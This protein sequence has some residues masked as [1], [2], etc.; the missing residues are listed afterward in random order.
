MEDKE[1]KGVEI[2][3]NGEEEEKAVDESLMFDQSNL[4]GWKTP[5]A[6]REKN[7]FFDRQKNFPLKTKE[8]RSLLDFSS[9]SSIDSS[10]DS[11][12]SSQIQSPIKT[13]GDQVEE[14]DDHVKEEGTDWSLMEKN[15]EWI[16]EKMDRFGREDLDLQLDLLDFDAVD[17]RLTEFVS[18]LEGLFLG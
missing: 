4:I 12:F 8:E 6:N 18:L 17:D 15:M 11:L 10:F 16:K 1:N 5:L 9:V 3:S 7:N 14:R 2:N 13:G